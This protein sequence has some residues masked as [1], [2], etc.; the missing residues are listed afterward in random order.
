M[1]KLFRMPVY[2][3]IIL[4]AVGFIGCSNPYN[5]PEESAIPLSGDRVSADNG[6]SAVVIPIGS[7][8][9]LAKIGVDPKYPLDGHYE[10]TASFALR[11]WV[12][13]GDEKAPFSGVL[14]GKNF[15]LTLVNFADSALAGK[16]YLGIFGYAKGA[17]VTKKA[18]LENISV[19]AAILNEASTATAGQ[20]VGL[21]AGYTEDAEI[22]DITLSGA[23]SFSSPN[24]I[25][26]GGI[27]GYAQ[28]GTVVDDSVTGVTMLI[29]GGAGGSLV[30]GMSYNFVGGIA[31]LF[32]GEKTGGVDIINCR[33]TGD[34]SAICT[35]QAAQ[36]FCGGIAGGSYY[37][38]T[39]DYQGSI[40]DCSSTGTIT[41]KCPGFWS[42]AGG[43]AGCI[44]GDGDGTHDNTTRIERCWATGTVTVEDSPAGYPYVGGIVGYNYYGALVSQCWFY[45]EVLSNTD[46][47]YTG[48]IAGYNSQT[49]DH[50]SR[51]EDCWS[52]G[53]VQGLHNAGGIVGQ[54]Q[55]NTYIRRCYSTA[56]VS[57]SGDCDTNKPSTNPGLGGI[58][59]FNASNQSDSITACV[60]LNAAIEADSGSSFHRIVG[61]ADTKTLSNNYALDTLEPTSGSAPWDPN[62]GPSGVDGEDVAAAKLDQTFYED[63]GWNFTPN[64][65]VW[66]MDSSGYPRLQWQTFYP[67]RF[68]LE[69]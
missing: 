27:V 5:L 50:N 45:G 61:L 48:G 35:T 1:K 11:D 15:S 46:G 54:N 40:Q 56:T 21:L 65:G 63:L 6:V 13:I 60:A 30:P 26:L 9:D 47:N 17:S 69:D 38:F 67:S 18:K 66:E 3:G 33:N 39:T 28:S 62:I 64:T 59:G 32:K 19:T 29:D 2:L 34:I 37:Q 14:N 42:W 20:A 36:V 22:S 31:G 58:A 25:Y 41:A 68:K 24:N 53:L 57:T 51:I 7:A 8:T 10:L 12:P 16:S 55:V 43:I 52:G 23:F 4:I 49:A 44:V